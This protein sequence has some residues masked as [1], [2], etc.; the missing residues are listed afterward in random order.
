MATQDNVRDRV[1]R[2]VGMIRS[3]FMSDDGINV[4]EL[5]K[6]EFYDKPTYNQVVRDPNDCIYLEGRRSVIHQLLFITDKHKTK[7]EIVEALVQTP[8]EG[9]DVSI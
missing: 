2:K 5:L 7:E 8:Q 6:E 1:A 4:L 3:L 9:P